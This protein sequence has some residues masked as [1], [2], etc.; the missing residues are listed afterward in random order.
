[1]T[2]LEHD[3]YVYPGN[4]YTRCGMV[5]GQ[6]QGMT[7]RD[8]AALAALQGVLANDHPEGLLKTLT[9]QSGLTTGVFII[10]DAFIAARETKET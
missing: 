10:A 5:S 1:M 6:G 8:A 4:R 9:G 3:N 7:L 2:D